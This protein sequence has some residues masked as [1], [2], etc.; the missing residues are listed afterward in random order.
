[1][2]SIAGRMNP[3]PTPSPRHAVVL[4]LQL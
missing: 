3:P 2:H 4:H 1:M